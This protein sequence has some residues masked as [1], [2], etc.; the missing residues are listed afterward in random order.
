[1]GFHQEAVAVDRHLEM[2]EQGAVLAGHDAGGQH[3]QVGL[4]AHRPAQHMI[5]DGQQ[6]GD[7]LRK[8]PRWACF[9]VRSG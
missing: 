2:F 9:P 4:D 6:Q 7:P 3:Q 5:G 8:W 1:M